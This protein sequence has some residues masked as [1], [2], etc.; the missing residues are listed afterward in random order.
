MFTRTEDIW[1][2]NDSR[3]WSYHLTIEDNYLVI[4]TALHGDKGG[5]VHLQP[6]PHLDGLIRLLGDYRITGT[7]PD[8]RPPRHAW[9]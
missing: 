4:D 6:G 9:P 2:C 3:G 8:E 5:K 1:I 7:L